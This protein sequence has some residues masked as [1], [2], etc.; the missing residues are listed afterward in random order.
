MGSYEKKYDKFL[1]GWTGQNKEERDAD[2]KKRKERFSGIKK[3][4]GMSD[5]EPKK[6]K[7]IPK[8]KYVK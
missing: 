5:N 4:F 3:F 8:S 6:K 7:Q 1:E 2:E